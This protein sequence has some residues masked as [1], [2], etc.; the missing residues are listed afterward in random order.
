MYREVYFDPSIFP[1]E[2]LPSSEV[3]K[4]GRN[5]SSCHYIFQDKQASRVQFSLHPFKPF[6]SSV[7]SF[8]IKNLSKKTSLIVDSR[9]LRYLNKMD[10]PYRCMVRFGEY[11]FL[12]E[13][14]DGESLESFETQF[15]FLPDHSCKKTAGQHRAPSPRMAAS[16]RA[17]LGAPSPWRWMK[18]NG[19]AAS[20]WQRR[21]TCT[22]LPVCCPVGAVCAATPCIHRSPEKVHVQWISV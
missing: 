10:L 20:Q 5:S 2:K 17:T 12:L 22:L 7:L 3:V 18:T 6:N 21:Q 14:E 16:R 15:V 19:D 9:E 4:F 13:R 11:Q 1:R 8:E